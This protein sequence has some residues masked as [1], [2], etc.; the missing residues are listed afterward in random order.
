GAS[1]RRLRGGMAMLV[2][3][4]RVLTTL[5]TG[6]R[7]FTCDPQ[8][9]RI[10][11]GNGE[12]YVARASATVTYRLLPDAAHQAVPAAAHWE[13]NIHDLIGTLLEESLE[14]WAIA[15]LA[16]EEAP[17]ERLLAKNYLRALRGQ[18]RPW[19]MQIGSVTGQ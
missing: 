17:P 19:G 8:Q 10:Q 5:E 4:E 14:R 1:Q 18:A 11:D 12:I 2:G 3:G 6:E 9:V 7:R 13:E 16:A 15:L